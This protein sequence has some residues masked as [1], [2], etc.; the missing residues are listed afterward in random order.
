MRFLVAGAATL[1]MSAGCLQ[2][3][4]APSDAELIA[5]LKANPAA[6]NDAVQNMT[7][8]PIIARIETVASPSQSVEPREARLQLFMADQGVE[9]IETRPDGRL[10]SF[11]MFTGGLGV[12]GQMKSLSY[13]AVTP[14]GE[15]VADTDAE[16]AQDDRRWRVAVR[17]IGDGWYIQNS[18]C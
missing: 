14:E 17:S 9:A 15:V 11:T 4:P 10:V 13:S 8:E 3:E 6:F 2:R 12:S 16:I 5:R 1:I 7:T 18:C